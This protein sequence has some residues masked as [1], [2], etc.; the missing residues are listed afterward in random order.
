MD[1]LL[2]FHILEALAYLTGDLPE[3]LRLKYWFKSLISPLIFV[4]IHVQALKDY[5]YVLAEFEALNILNQA[6]FS[7]II[8]LIPLAKLV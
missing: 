6:I 7:F 4:K 2:I 5:Y 1:H 3:L 8:N